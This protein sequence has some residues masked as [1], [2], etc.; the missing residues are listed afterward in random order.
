[1]FVLVPR[2]GDCR[3]KGH[4]SLSVESCELDKQICQGISTA[5]NSKENWEAIGGCSN[6]KAKV[7]S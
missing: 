4:S 6:A 2:V 3:H 1:M 7:G 5:P